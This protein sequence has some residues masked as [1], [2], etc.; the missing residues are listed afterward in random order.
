[1]QKLFIT[2][3]LELLIK[4]ITKE[5]T[6]T[7]NQN[8]DIGNNQDITLINEEG[9]IK[10]E[11]IRNVIRQTSTKPTQLSRKY[12]VI[13]NFDKANE[14]TQNAFLKTLEEGSATIFLQAKS[15]NNI[16][17]TIL[18]RVSMS[19]LKNKIEKNEKIHD[20]INNFFSTG[21]LEIIS[22][23]SK[24]Y[25]LEEVLDNFEIYLKENKDLENKEVILNK[26]Y[27]LKKRN[28]ETNLNKEIQ[29]YNLFIN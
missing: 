8:I 10:V 26:L 28:L 23:L 21:K 25:T 29:L 13:L 22:K 5:I 6:E 24:D 2:N 9:E 4:T 1:M 3:N 20:L 18:S 27:I 7:E 16:L 17:T 19:Q 12:I 14:S 11:T 15:T